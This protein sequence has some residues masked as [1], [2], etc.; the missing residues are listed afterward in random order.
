[1]RVRERESYA[2]GVWK[3]NVDFEEWLPDPG[4]VAV[5]AAIVAAAV[6]VWGVISVVQGR[7]VNPLELVMFALVFT[8]VYFG[9]IALLGSGAESEE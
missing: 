8:V 2:S 5:A 9:G 7:G 4:A 3:T 1:M 6:V